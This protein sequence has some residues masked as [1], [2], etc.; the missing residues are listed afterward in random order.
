MWCHSPTDAIDLASHITRFRTDQERRQAGYIGRTP[1]PTDHGPVPRVPV[2]KAVRV[3]LAEKLVVD[4]PWCDGID[5]HTMLALLR[6]GHSG[7][8]E[9]SGFR[10]RI[11]GSV[12]RSRL[13]CRN[14]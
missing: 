6:C 1:D 2:E 9:N 14:G 12:L 7:Q 5:P 10:R 13:P 8:R 11:R 4:E 3:D